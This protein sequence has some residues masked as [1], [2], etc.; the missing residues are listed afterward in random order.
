MRLYAASRLSEGAEQHK[1]HLQPKCQRKDRRQS[2][3]PV[4]AARSST[5][6]SLGR[7]AD[8]STEPFEEPQHA[9]SHDG[10]TTSADGSGAKVRHER[11]SA[12]K[13][14]PRRH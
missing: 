13:L 10:L 7:I 5:G 2:R 14:P 11:R 8:G 6:V 9:P 12:A 4:T 1:V 3:V